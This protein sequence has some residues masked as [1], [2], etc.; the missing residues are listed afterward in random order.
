M[1][2]GCICGTFLMPAPLIRLKIPV[3]PTEEPACRIEAMPQNRHKP[4]ERPRY[5]CFQRLHALAT[6]MSHSGIC[7]S[8]RL[9]GC[10]GRRC[11]CSLGRFQLIHLGS[12]RTGALVGARKRKT[13]ATNAPT[14]PLNGT[15]AV[16]HTRMC[17]ASKFGQC[18]SSI[19]TPASPP[20][21]P[22]ANP[23][24]TKLSANPRRSSNQLSN[25]A[26]M[27]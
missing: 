8:T 1:V 27:A 5:P 9:T 21:V 7:A 24:D 6:A 2:R 17:A 10:I 25:A 23:A 14:P 19:A 11:P 4:A 13:H 15:T 26:G 3:I 18:N 22:A 20:S 16:C 12:S